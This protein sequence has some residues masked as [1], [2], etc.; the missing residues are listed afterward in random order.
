M[1]YFEDPSMNF[2]DVMRMDNLPIYGN[3]VYQHDVHP[4]SGSPNDTAAHSSGFRTTQET[5]CSAHSSFQLGNL[6]SLFFS[7]VNGDPL[8]YET[9]NTMG[10]HQRTTR[11]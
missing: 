4:N 11:T 9:S 3:V 2:T 1:V 10:V 8:A 6:S 7:S 5:A